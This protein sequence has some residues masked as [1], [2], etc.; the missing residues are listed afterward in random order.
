MDP[1]GAECLIL[2]TA[3]GC[4]PELVGHK[5]RIVIAGVEW[6][7]GYDAMNLKESAWKLMHASV[8]FPSCNSEVASF[9]RRR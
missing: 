1:T 2:E 4:S 6:P 5:T 8:A 3:F 7:I 9:T